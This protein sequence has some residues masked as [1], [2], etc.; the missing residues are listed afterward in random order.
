MRGK[1]FA[2]LVLALGCGLVASIGITQVMSKQG[3]DAS[4]PAGDTQSI[5]VAMEDIAFGESVTSQVLRLEEWPKGK[6]PEGALSKIEDVEGR[7]TRTILYA[8]EPLLERKLLA[9]GDSGP[10]VSNRIPKGYRV[11]SV[12]VDKVSG[13]SSMILPG[14]RVDVMLYLTRSPG[15]GTYQ[16]TTRTILQDVKV[17][18]VNDVVG[19][20]SDQNDTSIVAQTISLLVTPEQAQQV[21]LATEMGKI[22][23]VMRSPEDQDQPE[24]GDSTV[25][26]IFGLADGADREQERRAMEA[27]QTEETPGRG[28]GGLLNSLRTQVTAA[29]QRSAALP[30]PSKVQRHTMRI[31]SGG[32][33][34]D[35]VLESSVDRS[36]EE[37]ER[38][39]IG[40]PAGESVFDSTGG[41]PAESPPQAQPPAEED[42]TS[43]EDEVPTET[44][45][46]N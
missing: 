42:Q 32:N 35:M 31:V 13:S 9:K 21:M 19:L 44:Q 4:T 45:E 41:L 30:T 22:R 23:L 43:E 24:V 40:G 14:D 39:R 34:T 5:F 11:I 38:W 33:V 3:K 10:G 46:G 7:R 18:A 28:L 8:G 2:L 26:D 6:V 29:A 25:S 17:F 15:S 36:P 12:Q 16:A 20:E 37:P 1:S 27:P